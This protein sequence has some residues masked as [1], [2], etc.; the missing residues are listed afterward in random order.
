MIRVYLEG[1][2]VSL[3]HSRRTSSIRENPGLEGEGIN[4]Y[5][6]R[7]KKDTKGERERKAVLVCRSWYVVD[8]RSKLGVMIG[9]GSESSELLQVPMVSNFDGVWHAGPIIHLLPNWIHVRPI[10]ISSSVP[11]PTPHWK[12]EVSVQ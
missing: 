6:P 10:E 2:R 7:T 8:R 5:R 1:E 11:S 12:K 9:V 3:C 4:V